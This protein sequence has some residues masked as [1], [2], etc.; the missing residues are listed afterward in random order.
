[1]KTACILI[2]LLAFLCLS[3][4]ASESSAIGVG[5]GNTVF[6]E[7]GAVYRQ[8]FNNQLGVIAAIAGKYSQHNKKIGGSLAG[9]YI[10]KKLILIPKAY[11]I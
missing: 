3:A 5:I 2:F 8:Y 11:L 7:A 4:R 9:L 10:F 6:Y 1:M